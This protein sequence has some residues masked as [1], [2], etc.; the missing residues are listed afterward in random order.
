MIGKR[1]AAVF[2]DPVC[3]LHKKDFLEEDVGRKE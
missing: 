3:A 1:K 2:P